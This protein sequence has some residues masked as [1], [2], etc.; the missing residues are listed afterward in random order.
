[1]HRSV[2]L[3]ELTSRVIATINAVCFMS[4]TWTSITIIERVGRRPLL[5][6]SAACMSVAFVGIAVSVGIG[7]ANPAS[8][9]VP[10]IVA[11]VFMFLYFIAFSFGWISVPWL[12]PAEINSLSMRS[13]GSTS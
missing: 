9:L 1:L 10:G 5:M 3:P 8:H 4:A 13:K 7:Q 11:T 6:V 12:Y 2:G